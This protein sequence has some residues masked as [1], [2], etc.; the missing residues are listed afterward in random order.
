VLISITWVF[1]SRC[2]KHRFLDTL[3]L[4]T[5]KIEIINA[6]GLKGCSLIIEV[7]LVFLF[8]TAQ[9]FPGI[10]PLFK[11][12]GLNTVSSNIYYW[13]MCY[14]R[15]DSIRDL[16]IHWQ[17]YNIE[18]YAIETNEEGVCHCTQHLHQW[19]VRTGMLW[20]HEGRR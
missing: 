11:R 7:C 1:H 8:R 20:S 15:S 18:W 14:W 4:T 10:V 6:T 17:L 12:W 16:F 19:D 13:F 5:S 3:L 9:I 2:V